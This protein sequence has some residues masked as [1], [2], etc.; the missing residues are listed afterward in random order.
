MH[1]KFISNSWSEN[2]S[3]GQEKLSSSN[4]ITTQ[5]EN[6]NISSILSGLE[7][8]ID[9]F[10]TFS[11]LA[12]L[13]PEQPAIQKVVA[14]HIFPKLLTDIKVIS[15]SIG[16]S[17]GAKLVQDKMGRRFVQKT[18]GQ[19]AKITPE[20]LQREY[21]TTQGYKALGSSVPDQHLYPPAGSKKEWDAFTDEASLVM[22]S[23]YIPGNTK[24]LNDYLNEDPDLKNARLLEVQNLV[25]KNF[26]ADCL[27][28]NWDVVGLNY[29][30]IRIDVDTKKIWRVDNG[31]GLDY[32][33]QGA[34]KDTQFFNGTIIEFET[35][36]NPGINP[37]AATIF[38]TITDKEIIRQI[39]E[40]LP[41][42]K[43]FLATIP[44]DLKEVMDARFDYLIGYKSILI[45]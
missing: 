37:S 22:L 6:G 2:S 31:S 34:K 15:S 10:L 21:A 18:A 36:R 7:D 28:A 41:R 17:T 19:N 13:L 5:L 44:K 39:D 9:P 38:G 40:I 29:D 3:V 42:R 43:A 45:H 20:H 30:N 14:G 25:Q 12:T 23:A 4:E 35:L 1:I 16:G 26:V 11:S 33:A 27:L 24:E 32:R 8:L